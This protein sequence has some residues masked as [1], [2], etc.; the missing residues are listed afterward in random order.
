MLPL[1]LFLGYCAITFS[2]DRCG[3]L[4]AAVASG[5]VVVPD[6]QIHKTPWLAQFAG[7]DPP[8]NFSMKRG[9]L[10]YYLPKTNKL[11]IAK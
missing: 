6:G 11:S 8:A 4:R 5:T 10:A 7:A 2:C 3:G 9:L 1:F